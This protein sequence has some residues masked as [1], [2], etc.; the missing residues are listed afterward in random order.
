MIAVLYLMKR[1]TKTIY[2]EVISNTKIFLYKILFNEVVNVKDLAKLAGGLDNVENGNYK[3]NIKN[4][5][6]FMKKHLQNINWF[7]LY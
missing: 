6:V 7:V 1:E 4:N 3:Y 5:W 2:L